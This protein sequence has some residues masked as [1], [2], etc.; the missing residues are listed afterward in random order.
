MAKNNDI[1]IP[2][3]NLEEGYMLMGRINAFAAYVRGAR[4]SIDRN[5]CAAMLGFD[6]E[7]PKKDTAQEGS[8]ND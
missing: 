2:E 1:Y 4:Y 3:N 5:V 8:D 7:E 6:L